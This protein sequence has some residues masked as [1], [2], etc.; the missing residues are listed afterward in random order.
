MIK[1]KSYFAEHNVLVRVVAAFPLGVLVD[2]DGRTARF[3]Y[4]AT[5]LLLFAKFVMSTSFWGEV[6]RC[7]IKYILYTM[8]NVYAYTVKATI[9]CDI[10]VM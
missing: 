9:Y 8:A 4:S 3:I 7:K 6:L 2:V 1:S 10:T 5:M